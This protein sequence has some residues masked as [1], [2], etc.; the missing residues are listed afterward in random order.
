MDETR[1]EHMAWCKKLAYVD[2]GDL[3]NALASMAS[4]VRKH[5]ET[6]TEATTA[7]LATLGPLC[8]M[9]NDTAGMRR[10]IEGFA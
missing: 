10:L 7:L 6:D 5:P 9:K 1:A 8:V 2:Q 4:D 3:V